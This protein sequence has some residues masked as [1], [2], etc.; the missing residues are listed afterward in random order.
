MSRIK[1]SPIMKKLLLSAVLLGGIL[2]TSFAHEVVGFQV[3]VEPVNTSGEK[4]LTKTKSS[5]SATNAKLEVTYAIKASGNIDKY[6]IQLGT[7]VGGD[8]KFEHTLNAD[9]SNLP[10]GITFTDK[11]D[12]IYIDFGHYQGV[13]RFY[14][15]VIAEDTNGNQSL[16][17]I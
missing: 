7:T 5:F 8:E 3:F 14:A 6:H 10:G 2:A 12:I 11:G 1:K 13:Q 9:G 15:E 17:K 4:V 16:P